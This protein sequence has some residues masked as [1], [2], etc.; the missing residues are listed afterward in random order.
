[1]NA[2]AFAT[3]IAYAPFE[4]GPNAGA[5]DGF[6]A[7]E[8]PSATAPATNPPIADPTT[9]FI[10]IRTLLMTHESSRPVPAISH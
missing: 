3:G 6:I 4:S 1:L 5:G 9:V 7:A 8:A 2:A 10:M